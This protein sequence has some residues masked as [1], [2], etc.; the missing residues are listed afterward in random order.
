MLSVCC[1]N[2][3]PLSYV[4]PRIV[5]VLVYGIGVLLSVMVGCVVYSWDQGVMSVSVDLD[6][7]TLSRFV[8]SHISS[9]SMYC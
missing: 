6:V 9:V 7:E 1:L 3:T 2:V 5:G 8:W 4:T